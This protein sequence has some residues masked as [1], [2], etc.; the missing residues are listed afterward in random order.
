MRLEKRCPCGVAS[1][2]RSS[3]WPVG[4]ERNT[5]KR[6]VI[7]DVLRIEQHVGRHGDLRL[8]C[9]A[10]AGAVGSGVPTVEDGARFAKGVSRQNRVAVTRRAV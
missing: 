6:R 4:I 5:D 3:S 2:A 8:V 10:R 9:V 1:L 7:V